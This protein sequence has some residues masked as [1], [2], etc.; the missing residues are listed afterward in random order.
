MAEFN[1]TPLNIGSLIFSVHFSDSS[2]KIRNGEGLQKKIP[3]LVFFVIK[4]MFEG[5]KMV[6]TKSLQPFLVRQINL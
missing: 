3:I 5:T 1:F 2:L 6:E 4:E